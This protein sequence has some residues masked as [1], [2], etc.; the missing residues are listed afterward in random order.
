MKCNEPSSCKLHLGSIGYEEFVKKKDFSQYLNTMNRSSLISVNCNI[1]SEV[2]VKK[3]QTDVY[4]R[5][6]DSFTPVWDFQTIS[7]AGVH[8]TEETG[9]GEA[10]GMTSSAS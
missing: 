6:E 3:N 1:F 5:S 8:A 10:R 2:R 9:W 7:T 4:F